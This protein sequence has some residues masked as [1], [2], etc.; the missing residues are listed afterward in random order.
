MNYNM[1]NYS[2]LKALQHYH[3]EKPTQAKRDNGQQLTERQRPG[4]QKRMLVATGNLLVA[5]GEKL[6]GQYQV[7]VII[8]I[9]RAG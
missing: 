4:W 5:V 3:A 2:F 7:D 9:Q 1:T 8:P 6:Q